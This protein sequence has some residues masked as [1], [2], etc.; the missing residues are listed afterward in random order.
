MFSLSIIFNLS[1]IDI[2]N[3]AGT[4]FFILNSTCFF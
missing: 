3:K 4:I 2:S 1:K